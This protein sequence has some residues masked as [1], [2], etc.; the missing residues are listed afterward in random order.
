VENKAKLED[1]FNLPRLAL[2]V[3]ADCRG[4][5]PDKRLGEGDTLGVGEQ[6]YVRS[7]WSSKRN[8][9]FGVGP[10]VVEEEL[11]RCCE[12]MEEEAPPEVEEEASPPA[13]V[14]ERNISMAVVKSQI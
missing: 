13:L 5:N 6:E 12:G 1:A 10:P 4:A 3:R 14:F 9:S 7:H 8:N 11:S 2:E